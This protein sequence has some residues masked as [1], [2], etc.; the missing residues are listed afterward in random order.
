MASPSVVVA[1][2]RVGAPADD[3]VVGTAD[4]GGLESAVR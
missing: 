2:R 4:D 1:D 3:R